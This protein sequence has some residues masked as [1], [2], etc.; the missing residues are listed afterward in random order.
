MGHTVYGYPV[1]HGWSLFP[2]KERWG[3][4][5]AVKVAQGTTCACLELAIGRCHWQLSPYGCRFSRPVTEKQHV[6]GQSDFILLFL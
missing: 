3:G 1:V 6:L 5:S 4:A 2:E